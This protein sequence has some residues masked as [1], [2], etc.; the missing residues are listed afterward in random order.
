MAESNEFYYEGDYV[1]IW[2]DVKDKPEFVVVSDGSDYGELRIVRRDKLIK[3]ED[4]WTWKQKQKQADDLRL[5]TAKAE[6][7]FEK[8]VE[9]V[10]KA[11]TSTLATRMKM[12]ILFGK[13]MAGAGLAM[14]VVDELNKLVREETPKVIKDE[15]DDL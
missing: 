9:K 6:E 3:K 13:E 11:A 4:S 15:K 14:T 10:I 1:Y 2:A 8:V 7:Q 5:V 12:N